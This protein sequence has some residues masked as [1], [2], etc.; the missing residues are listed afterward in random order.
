M[1]GKNGRGTILVYAILLVNFAVILGYILFLKSQTLLENT[2]YSQM[3]TKL[4]KNIE[5]RADSCMDYHISLNQNGSG[6]IDTRECPMLS[7]SGTSSGSTYGESIP[8]THAFDSGNS[9]CSG[10]STTYPWQLVRLDYSTDYLTFSGVTFRGAFAELTGTTTQSG[11]LTDPDASVVSLT[12]GWLSGIDANG[13]SDN[14]RSSSTGVVEYPNT[15]TDDDDLA[16]K[17]TYGFVRKDGIWRNIFWNTAKTAE[18]IQ[19]N[20]NNT[21][22]TALLPSQTSSGMLR[23]DL[24]SS[25]QLKILEVNSSLYNSTKEFRIIS[26]VS[27]AS[28]TGA[29]GYLQNDL[30]VSSGTTNA[31][32]FDLKNTSYAIFLSS[33]WAIGEYLK[34]KYYF[35]NESGNMIYTVPLDDA[36]PNQMIYY[37]NDIIVDT[38]G[39]YITKEQEF[40]RPK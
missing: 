21:G 3:S 11:T 35:A 20:T 4:S 14:Y 25:Y 40:I 2:R 33:S 28:N 29:I 32:L 9:F 15:Y 16:R 6:F 27:I 26:S 39:L 1:L 34:Y 10:A 30:S 13:N 38:E 24:D 19:N 12:L 37:G 5:E 36:R 22:A 8:T 23:L 17:V 18:V 31:K 7:F